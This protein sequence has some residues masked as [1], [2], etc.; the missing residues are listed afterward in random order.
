M[1]GGYVSIQGA[2]A[3]G[4]AAWF[5]RHLFD[6]GEARIAKLLGF[7]TPEQRTEWHSYRRA[8]HKAAERYLSDQRHREASEAVTQRAIESLR[9][10]ESARRS[11]NGH[12]DIDS[13]RE[14]YD[15]GALGEASPITVSE[16][17]ARV[18]VTPRHIRRLC[19]TSGLGRL[20]GGQYLIYPREFDVYLRNRRK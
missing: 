15:G 17:A 2:M 10:A 3:N 18:G 14:S 7:A 4:C 1:S 5:A 8:L 9:V 16:A 19:Q 6:S 13:S 12:E 11:A 20:I